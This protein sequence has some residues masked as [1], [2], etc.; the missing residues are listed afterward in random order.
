[1]PVLAREV[2]IR[3]CA[4]FRVSHAAQLLC[5]D[6]IGVLISTSAI[7]VTKSTQQKIYRG[8]RPQHAELLGQYA[9]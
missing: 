8:E 7:E 3:R 1:M 9:L 5:D 4:A 6:L 2:T